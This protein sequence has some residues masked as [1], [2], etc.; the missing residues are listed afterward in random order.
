[1]R[2]IAAPAVMEEWAQKCRLINA[3]GPTEATVCVSLHQFQIG[4]SY[5]NIGRP[6]KNVKAYVLDDKLQA[7]PIGVSGELYV[8]GMGVAAEIYQST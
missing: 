3:Y 8:G 2:V 7:V 4:D 1:M 5:V 6:M